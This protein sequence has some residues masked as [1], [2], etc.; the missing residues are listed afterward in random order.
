MNAATPPH[1]YSSLP[2]GKSRACGAKRAAMVGV[3]LAIHGVLIT[4]L[5]LAWAD[6]PTAPEPPAITVALV[7][8]ASLVPVP[9]PAPAASAPA[10][11]APKR[12]QIRQTPHVVRAS[13]LTSS[14]THAV[15]F[16]PGLSDSQIAGAAS[17]DS[18][19]PGGA[20]N[21]AQRVQAALRKDP[22]VMSALVGAGGRALMVWDGAWVRA[23]GEDGNGLAALREA[24]MWEIAFAPQP[25]RAQRM[26]GLVL[27]TLGGGARV[28]LG[29][30]DWRWQDMVTV[31]P[32]AS[33][34]SEL[35]R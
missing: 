23:H 34:Q 8:G 4:A 31:S 14:A 15:D 28:A 2:S 17:A 24:V 1:T 9:T 16:G 10:K 21:M 33:A 20:C 18:G 27:F 32:A 22:L 5:L 7:D 26:H 6:P 29:T 35:N 19:P 3:S 30:G 12:N 13:V 25:C 11:P